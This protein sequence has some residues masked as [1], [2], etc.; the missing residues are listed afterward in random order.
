MAQQIALDLKDGLDHR[1]YFLLVGL[2]DICLVDVG[3]QLKVAQ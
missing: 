3:G 2:F 1:W